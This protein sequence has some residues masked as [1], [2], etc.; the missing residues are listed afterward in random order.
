MEN[1]RKTAKSGVY[2]ESTLR[3]YWQLTAFIL[4]VGVTLYM[5]GE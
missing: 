1:M 2:C 4:P 5:S 3:S